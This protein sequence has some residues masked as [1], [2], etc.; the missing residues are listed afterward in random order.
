LNPAIGEF[1]KKLAST[2][3]ADSDLKAI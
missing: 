1:A 2:F 3:P